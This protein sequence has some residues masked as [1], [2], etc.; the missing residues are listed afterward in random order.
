VRDRHHEQRVAIR[1]GLGRRLRADY[2][3]RAAAVID[4]HFGAELLGELVGNQP[5][6]HVIAAAGREWNDQPDRSRCICLRL[7]VPRRGR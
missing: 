2:A 5:P 1:R 6:H 7:C 3:A 4:I